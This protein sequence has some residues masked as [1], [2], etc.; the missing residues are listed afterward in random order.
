MDKNAWSVEL[1]FVVELHKI[2]PIL[3]RKKAS[4]Q[5][6]PSPVDLVADNVRFGAEVL[7]LAW[8][9]LQLTR[10]LTVEMALLPMF[11]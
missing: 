6:D 10:L 8:A 1:I 2:L 5:H 11:R 4:C 7:P 3:R 9:T